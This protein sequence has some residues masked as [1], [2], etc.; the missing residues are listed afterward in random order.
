MKNISTQVASDLARN[1]FFGSEEKE[2]V[3][4]AQNNSSSK[5]K[6]N[7]NEN[8]NQIALKLFG[9]TSKQ[10]LLQSSSVAQKSEGNY[11]S[12]VATRKPLSALTLPF[13]S[14][15][16]VSL[17]TASINK[18]LGKEA[19]EIF[20][21]NRQIAKRDSLNDI[22]KS[23]TTTNIQVQND[24]SSILSLPSVHQSETTVKLKEIVSSS[25][26]QLGSNIANSDQLA[27]DDEDEEDEED[28][29]A[30]HS[31]KQNRNADLQTDVLRTAADVLTQV[32]TDAMKQYCKG[33]LEAEKIIHKL[34]LILAVTN[35]HKDLDM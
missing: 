23:S 33:H 20:L 3:N 7:A 28:L 24:N 4:P 6:S 5:K 13:V 1:K 18:V 35:I 8:N 15:S 26:T 10:V 29:M 12:S 14:D 22:S 16:N 31:N 17:T 32:Q 11:S 19:Q 21:A 34:G 27:T 9:V 2:N 30:S 25:S